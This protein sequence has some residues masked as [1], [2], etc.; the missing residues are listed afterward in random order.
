MATHN[1]TPVDELLWNLPIGAHFAFW[2]ISY[3]TRNIIQFLLIQRF[4]HAP[5]HLIYVHYKYVLF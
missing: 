1:E 5:F 3:L 2:M 4:D